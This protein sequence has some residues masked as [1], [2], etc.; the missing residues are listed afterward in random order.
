MT[1]DSTKR[2]RGIRIATLV[3]ILLCAAAGGMAAQQ[4]EVKQ[5]MTK[6]LPDVPGKE[7]LMITVQYAPGASSAPHRHNADVFVYVLKGSVVMQVKGGQQVTLEPGQTFYEGPN[8][9]HMV[10]RNASAT[11]PAEFLVVMVKARGAP[12]L[13]PVHESPSPARK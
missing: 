6:E 3:A 5:L 7:T 2:N 1:V 12:S 9:V 13:V 8:D 4:A 10:S 11:E